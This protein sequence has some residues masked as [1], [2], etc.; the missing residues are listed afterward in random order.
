MQ[1][2]RRR[3]LLGAMT[4]LAMAG[5]MTTASAQAFDA[6]AYFKGKTI[7]VVINAGAGGGLDTSTR[8]VLQGFS[9][10]IPG[11]PRINATNIEEIPGIDAVYDAP[12]TDDRI[13]IGF[14][15]RAATLYNSM[16]D[17]AATHD[18]KKMQVA[19]GFGGNP[20]MTLIFN[21]AAKAYGSIKDASGS[22]APESSRAPSTSAGSAIRSICPAG[23]SRSR[24]PTPPSWP[25]TSCADRST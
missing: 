17:A 7:E 21:E 24:T 8:F 23:W 3:T 19:A 22:K 16:L 6:E 4:A 5:G 11:N 25:R 20:G 1:I 2:Q 13:T 9:D 18:A 14:T 15:T 10:Y 12:V